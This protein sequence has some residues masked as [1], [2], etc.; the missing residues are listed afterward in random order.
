MSYYSL[1]VLCLGVVGVVPL[2]I[3]I[4]RVKKKSI[5]F[6]RKRKSVTPVITESPV[7]KPVEYFRNEGAENIRKGFSIIKDSLTVLLIMLILLLI[8]I[9]MIEGV[10]VTILSIFTGAL[11]VI[12]GI[13]TK[14]FIENYVSGIILGYNKTIRI[15]D[16]ILL[17]EKYGTIEDIT[18]TTTIVRLWD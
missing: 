2:R 5:A 3:N 4:I 8:M 11:A 12:I 1:L 14:P 13:T 15:G 18:L 6:L 16:T 17:E 10:P 9:P 7:D